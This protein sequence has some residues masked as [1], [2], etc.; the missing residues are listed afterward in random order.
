MSPNTGRLYTVGSLGVAG[1]NDAHL[2]IA[3]L[4]N[5]AFAWISTTQHAAS[6]QLYLIDLTTG[7]ATPLGKVGSGE[8]LRGIA[9]EP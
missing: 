4:N 9:I 6:A 2:D 7:A 1:I 3:D 8:S 5:A